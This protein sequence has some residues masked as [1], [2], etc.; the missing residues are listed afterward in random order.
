[1][2]AMSQGEYLRVTSEVLKKYNGLWFADESFIVA[3]RS[4]A[5]SGGAG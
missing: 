2:R 4:A 5:A 3:R 1:M